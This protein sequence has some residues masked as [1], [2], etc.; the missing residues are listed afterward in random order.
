MGNL[1]ND[2]Q[3]TCL[4]CRI[5]TNG[6]ASFGEGEPVASEITYQKNAFKNVTYGSIPRKTTTFCNACWDTLVDHAWQLRQM[7]REA[8]KGEIE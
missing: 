2:Y 8:S 7:H 5:E 3:S 6:R 4:I 1:G